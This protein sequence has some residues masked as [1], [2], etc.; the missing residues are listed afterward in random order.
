M[1]YTCLSVK[2]RLGFSIALGILAG[3]TAA[4]VLASAR[5]G[6]GI[7]PDS[8]I[9]LQAADHLRH[10]Q[11]LTVPTWQA[12]P[13]TSPLTHFPPLLPLVLAALEL[14][15]LGGTAAAILINAVCLAGSAVLLALLVRRATGL[16]WLGL[17][18]GT[19]LAVSPRLLDVHVSVLS[20]PLFLSLA[21]LALWLLAGYLDRPR[22]A[23]LGLLAVAA[24]LSV[25]ARYVGVVVIAAVGLALL[26]WNGRSWKRRLA[27][28]FAFG[29]LACLPL[30]VWFVRNKLVAGS[31]ANRQ[32]TFH[33]VEVQKLLDGLENMGRWFMPPFVPPLGRAAFVVALVLVGAAAALLL[34]RPAADQ[35]SSAQSPAAAAPPANLRR[36]IWLLLLFSAAYA[37]FLLLSISFLDAHT[38]LD[39]RILSPL[40]P[41]LIGLLACLVAA[42]PQV[43][44]WRWLLPALALALLGLAV[45]QARQLSAELR[46]RDDAEG[47]ASRSWVHGELIEAVRRIAPASRPLYSN[48]PDAIF[49]ATGR[50]AYMF[51][52]KLNPYSRLPR[53]Q[54]EQ[55]LAEMERAVRNG[56]WVVHF[57]EPG[58]T[59]LPDRRELRDRLRLRPVIQGRQGVIYG[60]VGFVSPAATNRAVRQ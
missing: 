53:P 56:A 7:V 18:A 38:P 54:Y 21:L 27:D 12:D 40:L 36:T 8:V 43:T 14:A 6:A 44:R 29:L 39:N 24:A 57:N 59:Y 4:I 47:F 51:P 34:R 50:A 23:L 3:L 28:G 9:Y 45:I 30:A 13:P 2:H 26:I 37:G 20:E 22:P 49:H 58:R 60:L 1:D 46:A 42:L 19:F 31:A 41:A 55:E 5:G 52:Q 32:A 11:G 48:W 35:P 17:L 33:P 10:G 25:L 15:G 16:N